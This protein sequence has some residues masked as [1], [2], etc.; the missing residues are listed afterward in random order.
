MMDELLFDDELISLLQDEAKKLGL[1]IYVFSNEEVAKYFTTKS[2][3]V[4]V[5]LLARDEDNARVN[6]QNKRKCY[7]VKLR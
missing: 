5:I 3:K 1:N 2:N 6:L 7:V 4:G